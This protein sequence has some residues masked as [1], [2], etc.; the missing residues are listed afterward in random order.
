MKAIILLL[1]VFSCSRS[2]TLRPGPTAVEAI[3]HPPSHGDSLHFERGSCFGWCPVYKVD[4]NADGEISYEGEA[5]VV[6]LGKASGRVSPGGMVQLQSAISEL[7]TMANLDPKGC[8]TWHTDDFDVTVSIR[9]EKAIKTFADYHGCDRM[10]DPRQ[11]ELL[12]R[13][14][15]IE[16]SLDRILD[17]EHWIGTREQRQ[18]LSGFAR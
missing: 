14:R 17:I 5:W 8:A 16:D 9:S 3:G 1:A 7:K 15:E 2:S 18:A 6:T 4:V 13:L 11:D 10:K 12:K